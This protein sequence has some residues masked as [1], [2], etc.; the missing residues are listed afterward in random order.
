MV[1]GGVKIGVSEG[2]GVGVVSCS[3]HSE[4]PKGSNDLLTS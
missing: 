1:G 4:I 3:C 2:I